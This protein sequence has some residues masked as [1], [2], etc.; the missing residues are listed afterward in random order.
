MKDWGLTRHAITTW[1]DVLK[2]AR[3][4]KYFD[5]ETL[6]SVEFFLKNPDEWGK[7]NEHKRPKQA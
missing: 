3:S 1:A 6:K 5:E 2:V 7:Q 4:E